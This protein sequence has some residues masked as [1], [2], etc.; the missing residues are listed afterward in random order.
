MTETRHALDLEAGVRE[1][2]VGGHRGIGLEFGFGGGEQF[3]TLARASVD[4]WREF[5]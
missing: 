5:A 3:G 2:L 4:R 1:A